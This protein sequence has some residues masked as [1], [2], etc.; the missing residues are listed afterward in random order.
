MINFDLLIT[1][2]PLLLLIWLMTKRRP[3]ASHHALPLTALIVY[4]L[5][6]IYLQMDAI[7][8]GEWTVF[9]LGLKATVILNVF[10]LEVLLQGWPCGHRVLLR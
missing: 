3:W 6:L 10:C 8:V 5:M 2:F 4:G 7:L 9:L 1:V